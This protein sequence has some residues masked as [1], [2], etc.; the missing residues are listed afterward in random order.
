MRHLPLRGEGRHGIGIYNL[1]R[2]GSNPEVDLMGDL[3]SVVV[4]EG[5][6]EVCEDKVVVLLFPKVTGTSSGSC[7]VVLLNLLALGVSSV[8]FVCKVSEEPGEKLTELHGNV[9]EVVE[10][11]AL[12]VKGKVGQPD[13]PV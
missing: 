10:F 5:S 8:H 11:T 1:G 4:R 3:V 9:E 2:E 7:H 6:S 12:V 13:E